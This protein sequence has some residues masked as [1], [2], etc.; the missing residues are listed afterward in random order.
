V[1]TRSNKEFYTGVGSRDAPRDVLIYMTKVARFLETKGFK[2]RTGDARGSDTAFSNGVSDPDNKDLFYPRH[3][4]PESMKIASE[5]HPAWKRCGPRAQRLHGRNVFQVLGLKLDVP[6]KFV[7]CWAP[8]Q[9]LG[10]TRTAMVLAEKHGIPVYNLST[11][12]GRTA[13]KLLLDTL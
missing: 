9:R 13:F 8:V 2:L 11:P 7:V 12:Q 5:I 10:G 4:T 6:S 1:D 3:A